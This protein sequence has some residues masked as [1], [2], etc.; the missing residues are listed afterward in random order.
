M[1]HPIYIYQPDKIHEIYKTA[2]K[3]DSDNEKL[4]VLVIIKL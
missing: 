2:A 1:I 3:A 4:F